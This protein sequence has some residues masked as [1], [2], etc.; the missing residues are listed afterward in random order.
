MMLAKRGSFQ[1]PFGER[2]YRKLFVIATEG[3]KTEPQYFAA[4]NIDRRS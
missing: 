1:R 2:R 4:F 3:V